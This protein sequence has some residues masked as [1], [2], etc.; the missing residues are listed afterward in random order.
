MNSVF[1]VKDTREAEEAN[2]TDVIAM[3]TQEKQ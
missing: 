3:M 1:N 2:I